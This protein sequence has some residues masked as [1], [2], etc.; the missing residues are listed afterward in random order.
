MVAV[1]RPTA[2]AVALA[3]SLNMTLAS[4]RPGGGFWV[5]TGADRFQTD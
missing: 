2:L 3:E 1:S 5:Y 4:R